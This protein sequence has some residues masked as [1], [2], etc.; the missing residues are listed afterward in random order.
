MFKA[1]LD[2]VVVTVD[3][4]YVRNFTSILKMAAIQNDTSI[5][6]AD[7]VN[8]MGTVVSAPKSISDK[9]E[10][11]GFSAWDILPG[12]KAIF[13]HMVIYD[14]AQLDPEAEPIY[15]NCVWYGGREFFVADITHIFATIRNDKIRMQNGYVMVTEMQTPPK[16][17]LDATTKRSIT[18]YEATVSQVQKDKDYIQGDTVYYNPNKL[19]LYQINGK[20]FGILRERDILGVK[21]AAFN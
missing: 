2:K 3:T 12:D 15:K 9:R 10:Y 19:Q 7:Y 20:P 8:I 17:I 18:A 14:F 21:K 1:P 16:I 6:P 5:E 11:K 13:S 4:K